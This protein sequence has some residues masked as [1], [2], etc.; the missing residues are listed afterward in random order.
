MNDARKALLIAC[1]FRSDI[2]RLWVKDL[3][4]SAP[5]NE[6]A[7]CIAFHYV[8]FP[9]SGRR[10][11]TAGLRPVD[12]QGTPLQ[13]IA[14][15]HTPEAHPDRSDLVVL[16]GID[17]NNMERPE[18]D[19][20]C[21]NI[22]GG[23]QQVLDIT[24]ERCKHGVISVFRSDFSELWVK[25]LSKSAPMSEDADCIAFYYVDC[26]SPV[27]TDGDVD[28]LLLE[29]SPEITSIL[30]SSPSPLEELTLAAAEEIITTALST[31]REHDMVHMA[32]IPLSSLI[33]HLNDFPLLFRVLSRLRC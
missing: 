30:S 9:P 21:I 25:E 20:E 17:F 4:K 24:R 12:L 32:L 2:N 11:S 15:R 1:V 29:K 16:Y 3:S 31:G 19:I 6:D 8:D 5:M 18:G 33:L 28:L 23:Y 13:D 22:T 26:P 27:S 7:N 10:L 14:F